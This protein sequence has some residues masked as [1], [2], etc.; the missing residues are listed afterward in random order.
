MTKGERPSLP[1][2]NVRIQERLTG[3]ALR[4]AQA[5]APPLAA[6]WAEA[7]FFRP[8]RSRVPP[9][10]RPPGAARLRIDGRAGPIAAWSWGS[11][12]AVYLLHGWGGRSDQLDAFVAPLS[13]RGFRV[14]ALDGPAHGASAGRLSS[15]PEIG[16]ALAA[17]V[18]QAGPAHG[19]VAHSLGGAATVFA[20]REG[21]PVGRLVLIGTPADPLVWFA[22]FAA[23]LGLRATVQQ[24]IRRRSERRIRA[25]WDDLPLVPRRALASPPPLLV[26]HDRDD[27]EVAFESA[28]AIVAAWPGARLL[29]TH[30]LGHQRVLR[31]AAV[32]QAVAAFMDDPAHGSG[33]RAG[34]DAASGTEGPCGHGIHG[35][36][37][38]SCALEAELFAPDLR[39]RTAAVGAAGR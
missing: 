25:S 30:G 3:V 34:E 11:G 14:V 37:C 12:P 9:G 1:R 10:P 24:E 36:A 33:E 31:D 29:E 13:A 16:R 8:P 20:M 26:V 19:V 27:R 28:A 23:R 5:V 21:L 4:V 2:T 39:R 22:R 7:L 35:P 32:I 17:V 38:E 18:A 15:A 6:R